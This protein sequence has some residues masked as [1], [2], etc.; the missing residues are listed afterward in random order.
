MFLEKQTA[1]HYYFIQQTL[2]TFSCMSAHTWH[3][4]DGY[5]L[6]VVFGGRMYNLLTLFFVTYG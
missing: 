1:P 2:F 3:V 6:T 5:L 4:S